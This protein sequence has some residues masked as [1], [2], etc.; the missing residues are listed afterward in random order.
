MHVALKDKGSM[1]SLAGQQKTVNISDLAVLWD[2]EDSEYWS[3]ASP[4]V[5]M[6]DGQTVIYVASEDGLICFD[7]AGRVRW[8][9][10]DEY[11][12]T[13]YAPSLSSD[14]L[15]LYAADEGLNLSCYDTRTG[16]RVWMVDSLWDIYCTPMVGPNHA[17]YVITDYAYAA[18]Y[19]I[20]DLGDSARVEW[21]FPLGTNGY[22]SSVALGRNGT[23]YCCKSSDELVPCALYAIDSSGQMLWAD[24]TTYS[25]YDFTRATPAID[26]RDRI[27]V[28]DN[29]GFLRCVNPDGTIAWSRSVG[30]FYV[31]GITIGYDD[32]VFL[33]KE[34]G[35]VLCCDANGSELWEASSPVGYG[36]YNNV[37]AVSDS[38]ILV[39]SDDDV[40]FTVNRD[41]ELGWVYSIWDSLEPGTQ[42]MRQRDEDEC[43][44]P[45]LGPDGNIYVTGSECYFGI[46]WHGHTTA[47]TAWPTYNHDPAHSGWA[48]RPWQ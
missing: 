29:A 32:R 28:G 13:Y 45:V 39:Y 19:K 44:S 34:D 42:R 7:A 15:H 4:T 26:S 18:L 17:V 35:R 40:L 11:P 41:G 14:G 16:R 22:W 5:G 27:I 31:G 8:A 12:D 9:N 24:T 33:Q 36:S 46:G 38:S 23:A 3:E 20:R 25:W 47:A 2:T 43:G 48:G 21:S 30:E 6:M 1:T 37:C 10:F